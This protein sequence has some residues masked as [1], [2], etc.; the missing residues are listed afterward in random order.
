[1]LVLNPAYPKQLRNKKLYLA[2]GVL[3]AF[4]CKLTLRRPDLSKAAQTAIFVKKLHK[5]GRGNPYSELNQPIFFG[6]L[7]HSHAWSTRLDEWR[8]TILKDISN[9]VYAAIKHP[10]EMLDVVCIADAATYCLNK[11]IRILPHVEFEDVEDKAHFDEVIKMGDPR[12]FLSTAY[13]AYWYESRLFGHP[14]GRALGA[15]IS[16]LTRRIARD[17]KTVRPIAVYFNDIRHWMC[18]GLTQDWSGSAMTEQTLKKY[19]RRGPAKND[20]SKWNER[21]CDAP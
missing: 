2:G 20:M 13:M 7:A 3:A 16:A 12:G 6:L 18:F 8:L 19:V 4:E 11:Q 21:P 9:C 17:D 14:D 15:L 5:P 1:V 10:R